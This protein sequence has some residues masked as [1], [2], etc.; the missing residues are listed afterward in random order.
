ME[1]TYITGQYRVFMTDV[2]DDYGMSRRRVLKIPANLYQYYD[3]VK[4]FYDEEDEG[5]QIMYQVEDLAVEEYINMTS[6][7]II[8]LITNGTPVHYD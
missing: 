7:E 5:T 3:S 6:T 8:R 1:K 2:K 4:D